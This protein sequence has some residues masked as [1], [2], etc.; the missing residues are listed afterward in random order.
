MSIGDTLRDSSYSLAH[1]LYD[2]SWDQDDPRIRTGLAVWAA[3]RFMYPDP[4]LG[5]LMFY[6]D[7]IEAAMQ[8]DTTK[9]DELISKGNGAQPQD[10][11]RRDFIALAT[12][13]K[14]IDEHLTPLV[15]SV[16]WILEPYRN[17]AIEEGKEFIRKY[18]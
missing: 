14:A 13:I 8:G 1:Y 12:F 2:P 7:A 6:D 9:L 10:E 17:E 11:Q 18:G 4:F 16:D 3:L 15:P 5:G